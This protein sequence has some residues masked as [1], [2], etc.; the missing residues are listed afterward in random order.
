MKSGRVEK[1]EA[2]GN[3]VVIEEAD[4]RVI[5]KQDGRAVIQKD[6]AAQMRRVAPDAQITRG[7]LGSQQAVV[8]KS[9][10][11]QIVNET[12]RNGQLIRRFRR[13]A[14]GN[15]TNIIDNRTQFQS[16]KKD[17]FGR[18]LAIGLGVGVGVIAGAAIL[19][20]VVR[21]VRPPVVNVPREKYILRNEDSS[22]DDVYEALNAPPV[23]ED[24]VNRHYTLN[25]VRATPQLRDR[26]RR[27][28]LDDVTFET[29]S[30]AVNPREY[31]KLERIAHAMRRVVGR[32]PNEVFLIEGYT[33][34]VGSA[35]D[36][37]TLSDRRAESVS[38]ML[39]EQF[40]VPFENLTT[41]GYGE[42]YLKINTDGPERE[43]RRVAVRRITPLLA[44]TRND[45]RSPPP[46]VIKE[47]PRDDRRYEDR[48]YEDRSDDEERWRRRHYRRYHRYDENY[49]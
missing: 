25:Q 41:Q 10:N 14:S 32:N 36:N 2:G 47:R 26:M 17:R 48:R 23:D 29:G 13:D 12:D 27:V 37:L 11:V 9:D 1:V 6:E 15:E 3:R 49:R 22:E 20:S 39:T 28:D 43:N 7:K 30:W 4:K 31:R 35:D 8:T 21:D 24:R 42:E 44:Q 38:V 34:A 45:N 5:V 33:D 18:N 40:R 19:N 16:K 46:P